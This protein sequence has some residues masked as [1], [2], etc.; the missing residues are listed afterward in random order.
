M[1]VVF[2]SISE[3]TKTLES[4]AGL[5]LPLRPESLRCLAG[6][7]LAARRANG[8]GSGEPAFPAKGNRCGVLFLHHEV[9]TL[10]DSGDACTMLD[11]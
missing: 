5:S 8:L 4:L 11:A 6:D 7:F 3:L 2:R 1:S 10:S 9:K